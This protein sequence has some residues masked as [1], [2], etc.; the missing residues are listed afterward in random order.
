MTSPPIH[1]GEGYLPPFCATLS[2]DLPTRGML[3]T[4]SDAVAVAS[5]VLAAVAIAFTWAVFKASAE[6]SAKI[7]AAVQKLDVAMDRQLGPL[8]ESARETTSLLW[9]RA[10]P[11]GPQS[12]SE[13][14]EAQ[15]L[16]DARFA[17]IER[18]VQSQI[19]DRLGA[20][21]EQQADTSRKLSATRAS[22]SGIAQSVSDIAKVVGDGLAESRRVDEEAK[23]ETLGERIIELLNAQ[24]GHT[25]SQTLYDLLL[26]QHGP[27]QSGDD[28]KA[29]LHALKESGRV[30]FVFGTWPVPTVHLQPPPP[31]SEAPDATP[32][33]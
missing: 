25:D 4:L 8:S 22:V 7:D 28:F 10:F 16:G 9:D 15:R 33:T 18:R 20:L 17:E 12:D 1:V 29:T 27:L 3:M 32:P 14:S 30:R 11:Q 6:K 13:P 21:T 24:G 23:E 19:A 26:K 31:S 5:L 2:P